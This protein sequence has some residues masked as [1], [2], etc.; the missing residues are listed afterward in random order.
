VTTMAT[1]ISVIAITSLV[2]S[3]MDAQLLSAICCGSDLLVGSI[4]QVAAVRAVLLQLVVQS[5]QADA[6]NLCRSRFVVVCA[7]QCA[8]NQLLFRFFNCS[9]NP[10]MNRIRI[11]L[12]RLHL[13]SAESRRQMTRLD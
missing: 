5:L 9:A 8:Q 11:E 7:C 2:L 3:R 13:R 4:G 12:R 10:K 1:T 6:Q